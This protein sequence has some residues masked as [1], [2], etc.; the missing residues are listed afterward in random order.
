MCLFILDLGWTF[1][2]VISLLVEFTMSTGKKKENRTWIAF[3]IA[4]MR[5]PIP[6]M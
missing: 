3:Y 4:N 1:L 6:T 2:P 5:I